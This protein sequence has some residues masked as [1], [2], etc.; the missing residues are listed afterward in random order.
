MVHGHLRAQSQKAVPRLQSSAAASVFSGPQ[1][2]EVQSQLL[3]RLTNSSLSILIPCKHPNHEFLYPESS[4]PIWD[5]NQQKAARKEKGDATD[6]K[7]NSPFK[8]LTFKKLSVITLE[9][10]VTEA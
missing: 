1:G 4:C 8:K 10:S 5:R 2:S 9:I 7:D 6:V 3:G